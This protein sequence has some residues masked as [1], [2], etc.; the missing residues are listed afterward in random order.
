[1][2]EIFFTVLNMSI[3][4]SYVIL[5][6]LLVRL[7]MRKLPKKFSYALW[8]VAAFRLCVPVS[9]TSIISFFNIGLF[10]MTDAQKYGE[11]QLSFVPSNAAT[12]EFPRVSV[13]IPT[14]NSA[15][16]EAIPESKEIIIN[17]V[18]KT[19]APLEIAA[20][21]A[22]AVWIIGFTA[23]LIYG[24][25][26][27]V[28]A[29]LAMRTAV[30]ANGNVYAS[31]VINTPFVL[32][33]IKPRIY[34]P[35]G[36]E[37]EAFGYV[38]AHEQYHIK[39]LD[40]IV[41]PIAFLIL[42]VHWF[43]PLCWLAFILMSR[44]QE[45]SCD[46]KVLSMQDGIGGAYSE[47][48]LSFAVGKRFPAPSPLSFGESS[49]KSR[50][51][52]ALKFK[53]PRF[54]VSIVAVVLCIATVA[55]CAANP[56]GEVD[57]EGFFKIDEYIYK[58][59]DQDDKIE[60]FTYFAMLKYGEN[61]TTWNFWELAV[62]F[63]DGTYASDIDISLKAEFEKFSLTEFNFD[64]LFEKSNGDWKKGFSA[65]RIREKN[66][67]AWKYTFKNALGKEN[68]YYI[69]LQK[70]GK[71]YVLFVKDE[72]VFCGEPCVNMACMESINDNIY[73]DWDIAQIM[74]MIKSKQE[75]TLYP[76]YIKIDEENYAVWEHTPYLSSRAPG[77]P[78][79][80]DFEHTSI[81]LS[82]S[83]GYLSVNGKKKGNKLT[84][85]P[86]EEL[87][88]IPMLDGPIDDFKICSS[89]KLY[90]SVYNGKEVIYKGMINIAYSNKFISSQI[91]RTYG[92]YVEGCEE[93]TM[94]QG[95]G[96]FGYGGVVKLKSELPNDSPAGYIK[97]VCTKDGV[98]EF[99][100]AAKNI[101]G[102]GKKE[103]CYNVT[104]VE[105]AACTDIE[106]FKF[107]D[108]FA[109]FVLI[110]G[111]V[112]PIGNYFGGHGF[113][114]AVPC[115]LDGD[116]RYDLL[117][118]SNWGSGIGRSEI[119]VF[120]T[121]TKEATVLYSTLME[122]DPMMYLAVFPVGTPSSK[123]L[124]RLYDAAD[125]YSV[126]ILLNNGN[127]AD[128]SYVPKTY[129]GTVKWENESVVFIDRK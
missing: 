69:L 115:D 27:F 102:A 44:D 127:S 123:P 88:W 47:T 33:F 67:S 28:R 75:S 85:E 111:E 30:R 6:I 11:E 26:T 16:N 53:K 24:V 57:I 58:C 34:V 129:I 90:F 14:L 95:S 9:F 54:W 97:G 43:N 105:V 51:K 59:S 35:F 52:N 65:S 77:F 89:T 20:N 71:V 45:M 64:A 83:S 79:I 5:A 3:T 19:R 49:V 55:A 120:N 74:A 107:S 62:D 25:I 87:W 18:T 99:F 104:P 7:F 93:L 32:G 10:D 13:G 48:L 68:A 94:T 1:M 31:D 124:S 81:E 91:G 116:E 114:N 121:K 41:K 109:A 126:E 63:A 2:R 61:I 119:S 38:L 80:F 36:L 100:A 117:I 96:D 56:R 42:C 78:I 101:A 92:A 21:I 122:E 70:D 40:H 23:L 22:L 17:G 113:I 4:A 60:D 66:L 98:E 37:R 39:R 125:V 50:I 8:S 29:K 110:D 128:F 73:D 76:E 118:S 106:I 72:T 108:T 15:I 82:A 84:L 12:N 112:Y 103:N 46:E 86:G